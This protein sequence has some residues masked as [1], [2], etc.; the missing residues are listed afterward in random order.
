MLVKTS[1]GICA[2]LMGAVAAAAAPPADLPGF[3][4]TLSGKLVRFSSISFGDLTGDNVPEIVVGGSDGWL[5]AYQGNGNLLWSFNTAAQTGGSAIESKA[6]IADVDG[7]GL[8]EVVIG[9]GSTF[10]PS[11]HGR[12]FVF[13]HLGNIQ[14]QFVPGDQDGNGFKDGVYSSPAVVDLDRNDGG[15][16]EIVFGAWDHRVR[17]LHH[18]CS[19]YWEVDVF[20]TVWSSP[21][22]GDL[23]GDGSAEVVIGVDSHQAGPPQ[24][25]S[26]GGRLFV[27]HSDGSIA[28]GF[29]I[30]VDEVI[31]SSPALGDLDGDTWLDIVVG[32]GS[33]WAVGPPCGDIQLP[34][35]G[36]DIYAW[37]RNGNPLPGWPRAI[38]G[39]YARASPA[40]ADIDKDGALE[41]VIN[42]SIR[43]ANPEQ[44]K[45][46]V[47]NGNGTNVPGWPVQPVT[48]TTCDGGTARW[49]SAASPI[50]ADLTGDGDLEVVLHSAAE[51]VVWDRHG[52]QLSRGALGPPACAPADPA[53]YVL[54]ANLVSSSPSAGVADVDGDNDLDLVVGGATP[55]FPPNI[56][57]LW[58]WDFPAAATSA[59][60]WPV[61][62]PHQVVDLGT[63]FADGFEAGDVSRWS[64]SVP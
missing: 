47:L 42:S 24:N 6:A 62:L 60:P 46:Y 39:E 8:P 10:T 45:V 43:G 64:A 40:L 63:V 50:V 55:A 22:I 11:A 7:D 25:I 57:A 28:T 23:D 3:P 33:C 9:A 2:L 53:L 13:D 18:D 4:A 37:D 12:L 61:F 30:A 5:Y 56:G 1:I 59:T 48:P 34:G 31:T 15:K 17:A 52:N 21:A 32:T 44:G 29:P 27:F 41:V 19:I 14:C 51:L 54:T 16:L 35:V 36:D 26:R 38:P 49:A 58:A 20:D